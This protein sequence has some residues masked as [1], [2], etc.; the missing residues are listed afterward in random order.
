MLAAP[1]RRVL[2]GAVAAWRADVY[3]AVN[4]RLTDITGN[5][6]HAVFGSAVGADINDPTRLVYSGSKYLHLPGISGN[7]ASLSDSAA[8]SVTGTHTI[9][10]YFTPEDWTPSGTQTLCG[11]WLATGEQ[12][13]YELQLDA[14][15]TISLVWTTDGTAGT[16]LFE[17]SSAAT[18]FTDGTGHWVWATLNHANGDVKFYTSDQAPTVALA[19]LVGTQLGTTQAGVATS[20]A[21]TTALFEVGTVDGGTANRFVGA[22]HRAFL[23]TGNSSTTIAGTVVLDIDFDYATQPFS[24]LAERSANAA[25][26]TIN[27][28]TTGKKAVVV[29]RTCLLFGTDDYL[30]VADHADLDFAA[31]DSFTIAIAFR[32]SGQNVAA[33][34]A[35]MAKKASAT[36]ATQGWALLLTTSGM[37]S[38]FGDGTVG[39]AN[40]LTLA[41][42]NGVALQ[43]ALVRDVAQAASTFYRAANNAAVNPDSTTGSL[44]NAE[45]LRIGRLSGAGT[46]Y[47]DFVF[48]AA[49]IFR[50]ALTRPEIIRLSQELSVGA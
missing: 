43:A 21:D 44:A 9:G 28:A 27:R 3:D 33:T 24:T 19:A 50:R 5:A 40:S 39:E 1:R 49:A 16:A 30:E 38:H 36:T 11:K 10:G 7:Y 20:V 31:G 25:T 29:D 15:G 2:A 18:G 45:V 12:R 48:F 23:T 46:A 37:T 34:Q 35:L 22:C 4:D 8:L 47:G 41:A 32:A 42:N 26:V 14:A 6:H 13:G 17:T